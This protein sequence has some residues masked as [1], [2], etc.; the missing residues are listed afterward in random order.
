MKTLN[1][2]ICQA[3]P[4]NDIKACEKARGIKKEDLSKHP[5]PD[6]KIKIVENKYFNFQKIL[7]MFKFIK[8]ASDK[9]EKL[10]LLIPNPHNDYKL[11]ANMINIFKVNC[12]NLW[13]FIIDEFVD[14]DEK[15]VPET[16]PQ[17]FYYSFLNNFYYQINKELRPPKKQVI[18]FTDKNVNDYGKMIEDCGGIDVSFCGVGWTGHLAYIEPGAPEFEADSLEEFLEMGPR[19]VTLNPIS[20]AQA[21]LMRGGDWSSIPPKAVTVGPKEIMM[22]KLH[23]AWNGHNI[24]GTNVSWMNFIVRLASHGPVTKDI[25]ASILQLRRTDFF[26]KEIVAEDIIY[27]QIISS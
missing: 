19:I 9:E 15:V 23:Q 7:E 25:P 5:N 11:L 17:G 1:H 3:I 2:K 10:V 8:E 6:F 22:A 24:A 13:T 16:W 26:I 18:G 20:I 27:K 12:K 21:S 14:E 4:F